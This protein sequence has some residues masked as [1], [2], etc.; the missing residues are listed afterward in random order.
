MISIIISHPAEVQIWLDIAEL[1]W[2]KP[3]MPVAVFIVFSH[4]VVVALSIAQTRTELIDGVFKCILLS[5]FLHLIWK[6]LQEDCLLLGKLLVAVLLPRFLRLTKI[7][8]PSFS[9]TMSSVHLKG[10]LFGVLNVQLYHRTATAEVS[11][12]LS[13]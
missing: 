11:M 3:W 4:F 2:M 9:T 12:E 7:L 13:Q 1:R 8:Q 6:L 10:F 5:L